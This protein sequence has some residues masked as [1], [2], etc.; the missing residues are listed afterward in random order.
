[1]TALILVDLQND[2]MPGGSL[3]VKEG[4]QILPIVN[5]LLQMPFDCIVATKDWHP[6]NHESFKL[7][8]PVHCV[9]DTPGAEFYPGWDKKKVHAVFLKGIDPEV[10][11]YSTFFDNE[12]KRSTG[13]ED[14]L[15]KAKIKKLYFA[16]LAT[17][18]CVKYSVLDARR[19]NFDAYVVLEG[20]RGVDVNPE[21][22][23]KALQEMAEAGAHLIHLSEVGKK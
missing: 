6:K 12:H 1:M 11:S 3:A 20:I 8:W 13:L 15:Q 19:L 9:Q 23:K 7:L 17:D 18:Y 16:G 5:Q 22:S 21:D 14:F 4:D 10:D 2:F